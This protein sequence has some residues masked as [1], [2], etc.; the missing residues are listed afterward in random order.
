MKS[1]LVHRGFPE[2]AEC[3]PISFLI[4]RRKCDSGSQG[5]LTTHD[6]M[7]AKKIDPFIE[8]VHRAALAPRRSAGFAIQF[9]HH[10][11][12]RD[13]LGDRLT[14]FTITCEHIIVLAQ[15]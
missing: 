12:R 5:N 1:P 2:E 6:S 10:S 14:V 4:L 7:T 8:D 13:A 9:G 3:H 11:V 15:G